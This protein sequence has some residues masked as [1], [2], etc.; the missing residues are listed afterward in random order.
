MPA[1]CG[2]FISGDGRADSE[3]APKMETGT[4]AYGESVCGVEG[5]HS[6][7]MHVTCSVNESASDPLPEDVKLAL[8]SISRHIFDFEG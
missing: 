2:S 3:N 5:G 8:A 6:P 1:G 7:S 4:Y